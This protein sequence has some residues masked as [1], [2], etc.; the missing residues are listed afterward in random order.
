MCHIVHAFPLD[1]WIENVDYMVKQG[2]RCHMAGA[3]VM[4]H[5][6]EESCNCGNELNLCGHL[7]KLLE[8]NHVQ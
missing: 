5:L 4:S 8:A 3:L 7:L 2:I 1:A 6:V